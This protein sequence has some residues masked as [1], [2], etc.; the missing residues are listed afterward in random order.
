[1]DD[2]SLH[3][4][5]IVENSVRAEATKV[6]VLIDVSTK[7]NILSLTIR[8]NGKGMNEEDLQRCMDPF[9]TTKDCKRTGLGISMVQQSAAEAC[10]TFDI[11]SEQGRGTEMKATFQY[12]HLDRK[13][14]GDLAK[15]C[16]VLIAAFPLIDLVFFCRKDREEFEIDTGELKKDLGDIPISSPDVLKTLRTK[17]QEGIRAMGLQ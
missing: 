5:D 10:G 9:F 1:M 15:T 17:I 3:I 11:S 13:P 2:L 8:D 7:N 4:M 16:Y 12:D 6:C 14:L